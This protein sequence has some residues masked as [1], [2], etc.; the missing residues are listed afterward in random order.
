MTG[1][2]IQSPWSRLLIEGDKCVE[3]RSY[4]IPDKYVGEDLGLIETP[5]KDGNFKARIIGV[6]T[7]SHCFKYPDEFT[8]KDDYNRHL[9]SKEDKTFG[10]NDKDKYGWVV[11]NVLHFDY[12]YNAP[13]RKGIVF[14]NDCFGVVSPSGV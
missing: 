10:W 13:L 4:P 1:I 12:Y 11:S 7:F 6:I 9:V 8:W 14:T 2:N 3:T 5:G